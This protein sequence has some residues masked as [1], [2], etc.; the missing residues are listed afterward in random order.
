MAHE[1]KQD[2]ATYKRSCARVLQ[3][4]PPDKMC[5]SRYILDH[6][7]PYFNV[8]PSP[9]EL[10]Q[11]GLPPTWRATPGENLGSAG[12]NLIGALVKGNV[13][14]V[15]A[16]I[17]GVPDYVT[18]FDNAPFRVE[19]I[20]RAA[21]EAAAKAAAVTAEDE[22]EDEAQ[23]AYAG[24]WIKEWLEMVRA[25]VESLAIPHPDEGGQA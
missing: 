14:P 21:R 6:F 3:W 2:S 19:A 25:A 11:V 23:K 16:M 15:S 24:K 18:T 12:W 7:C 22:D 20:Q 17:S 1:G 4:F 10:R 5:N 9:D 8:P 13:L